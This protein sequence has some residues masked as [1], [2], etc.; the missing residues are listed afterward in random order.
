MSRPIMRESDDVGCRSTAR[1]MAAARWLSRGRTC[2][3]GTGTIAL[4]LQRLLTL[5]IGLVVGLTATGALAEWPTGDV[6]YVIPFNPG[7]ESDVSARL[8]QKYFEGLTG[9]QLVIRYRVGG[10]GAEAWSELNQLPADG[11]VVMGTNLPH[12][13]MQ[14][15]QG[16]AGYRTDEIATVYWFHYTPDAILVSADSEFG[17]LDQLVAFARAHPDLVTFS[18]SGTNTANHIAHTRFDQMAGIR[19]SYLP[20]TGTAPAERAVLGGQVM[21]EWGYSTV[22]AQHPDGLRMLA[23][24]TEARVP[25]FPDVPTFRELGYDLV[26]GAYR[27][28]A[29]PQTTPEDVKTEISAVIHEINQLPAF[30]REMERAGFVLIDVPYAEVDGFMTEITAGLKATAAAMGVED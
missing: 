30:R 15:L 5:G 6:E 7:G 20:F 19:T 22:A 14:P 16:R 17:T 24:A 9:H 4:S 1:L 29:V 23:V 26:S 21:A 18:G 11:S 12:I 25:L 13:V 10:G 27:G 28:V 3:P 2:R 8:Q